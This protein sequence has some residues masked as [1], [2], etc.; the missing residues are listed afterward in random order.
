M[1]NNNHWEKK[2]IKSLHLIISY[3]K[4]KNPK[5]NISSNH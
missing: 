5:N 4:K 2:S 3:L 1:R